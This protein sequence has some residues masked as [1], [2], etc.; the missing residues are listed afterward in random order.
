MN[1]SLFPFLKLF[2]LYFEHKIDI[3]EINIEVSSDAKEISE[4]IAIMN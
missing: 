4:I 2:Y 1:K 3:A